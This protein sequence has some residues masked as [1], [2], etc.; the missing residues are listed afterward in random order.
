MAARNVTDRIGHGQ[1]SGSEGQ[2][3]A[4]K[5]NAELGKAAASTALPHPPNT[6]QNVPIDSAIARLDRFMASSREGMSE[7]GTIG[8]LSLWQ[9]AGN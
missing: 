2:G 7:R 6:S 9:G 3:H 1:D 5:S 4:I 8:Y